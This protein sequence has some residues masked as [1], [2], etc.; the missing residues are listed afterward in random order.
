MSI[1]RCAILAIIA[2]WMLSYP[3]SGQDETS[4]ANPEASGAAAD[5]GVGTVLALMESDR[6]AEAESMI[7]RIR[8]QRP[9]DVNLMLIHANILA[10][11]GKS[12]ESVELFSRVAADEALGAVAQNNLAWILVTTKDPSVY[13]P[14]RAIELI[15]NVLLKTP[16]DYHVWSTLAEV[17]YVMANY[18]QSLRAAIEAVRLVEEVDAPPRNLATYHEQL[19]KARKAVNALQLLE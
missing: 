18:E 7:S 1:K 16:D 5:N 4:P 14:E 17:H 10:G 9:D 8:I 13:D 3:S 19:E 11:Q 2:G 6:L 12:K 15:R